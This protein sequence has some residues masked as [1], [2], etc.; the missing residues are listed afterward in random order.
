M[1]DSTAATRPR[2]PQIMAVARQ[3]SATGATQQQIAAR[4][5]CPQ[6][7]VSMALTILRYAPELTD[8]VI[9][10][11][12]AFGPAYHTARERRK[13]SRGLPSPPERYLTLTEAAAILGID[14]AQV[15]RL[16]G[17]HALDQNAASPDSQSLAVAQI[18][19]VLDCS[20]AAVY[21]L[22]HNGK[23]RATR[24][25]DRGHYRVTA[26]ELRR[27]LLSSELAQ[28]NPAVSEAAYSNQGHDAADM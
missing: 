21:S 17:D 1:T 26:Q 9:A 8:E 3:M 12:A 6:S 13:A 10:G 24:S 27:Y 25:G 23:L 18:A 4:L 2:S 22:L 28:R 7:R 16:L 15:L 5:G 19:A 11:T 14:R 20:P